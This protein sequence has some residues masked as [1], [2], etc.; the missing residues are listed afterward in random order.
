MLR[1]DAVVRLSGKDDAGAMDIEIDG[2]GWRR[3]TESF[4][5]ILE[6]FNIVVRLLNAPTISLGEFK[7][8]HAGT[9]LFNDEPERVSA[10]FWRNG[11]GCR[12]NRFVGHGDGYTHLSR[13]VLHDA[14]KSIGVV[15]GALASEHGGDPHTRR[16]GVEIV[17]SEDNPG[18]H[19][20]I[21]SVGSREGVVPW[22]QGISA[23]HHSP[24]HWVRSR[25]AEPPALAGG[26]QE[27]LQAARRR[28]RWV[29]ALHVVGD[30]VLDQE[31]RVL[32]GQITRRQ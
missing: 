19:V 7:P 10:R 21:W 2:I 16:T 5:A 17:T 1:K 31:A 4:K 25:V 6:P 32:I 3:C 11:A 13:H 8:F 23:R 26:A 12:A 30:G 24:V 27:D 9:E 22:Q 20:A 14:G 29:A 18:S 28:C 15:R